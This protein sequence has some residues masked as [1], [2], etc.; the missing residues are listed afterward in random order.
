M[1]AAYAVEIG[2]DNE[3]DN[4]DRADVHEINKIIE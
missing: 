4:N 3:K 1:L 2:L